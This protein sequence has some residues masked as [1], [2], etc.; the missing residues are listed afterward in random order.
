MD[1]PGVGVQAGLAR[2]VLSSDSKDSWKKRR[3]FFWIFIYF[4]FIIRI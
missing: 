2:G 4:F 3:R 1:S